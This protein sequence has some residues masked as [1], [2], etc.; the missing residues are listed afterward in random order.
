[1]NRI[2]FD[3]KKDWFGKT[4]LLGP[5]IFISTLTI[6]NLIGVS[7]EPVI[8]KPKPL[9]IGSIGFWIFFL[10]AW[11]FTYYTIDNRTL[12]A[13]MALL[14][15]TTIKIDDI[16]EIK[17]QEFGQFTFGLSKDVLSIKLKNGRELNI[18]PRRPDDFIKEIEKR[19]R[20]TK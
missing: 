20:N 18:S 15:W 7:F 19:K 14:R 2:K 5:T 17:S 16:K 4:L 1:M 9:I 13:R 8:P 6:L 12:T 11:T 10:F 3:T